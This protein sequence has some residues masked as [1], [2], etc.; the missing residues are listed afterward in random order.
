MFI[1]IL[2]GYRQS[3]IFAIDCLAATLIDSIWATAM[4][5]INMNLKAKEDL[6]GKEKI[7]H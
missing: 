6:L 3:K 5:E 1:L 2:Y 4:K 7:S